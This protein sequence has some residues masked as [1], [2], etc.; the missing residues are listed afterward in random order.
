VEP[1]AIASM[2]RGIAASL[3][4]LHGCGVP[5]PR[6]VR[7]EDCLAEG[8]KKAIRLGEALPR[9]SSALVGIAGQDGRLG[10]TGLAPP[11]V[12]H[13][14]LHLDQLI[15]GPDGPVLIDLDSVATGD[16]E[17]DLAEVVVDVVLRSLPLPAVRAFV[18]ELLEGYERHAPARP[19]RLALLRALADA[20]FLTRC[21]RHLRRRAPGWE[22]ELEQA[23]GQ[24]E[25]LTTVLPA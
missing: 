18:G 21:H 5:T 19:I 12:V 10:T 13:G 24:H 11:V 8:R 25:V 7:S 6:V 14:D 22:A 1:D 9:C 23:L 16:A 3:A 15:A 4:A 17:L 20:E 2:A